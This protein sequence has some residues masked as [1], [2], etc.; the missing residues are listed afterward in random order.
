MASKPSRLIF[1]I[2]FS[3]VLSYFRRAV[4]GNCKYFKRKKNVIHKF[5]SWRLALNKPFRQE[6]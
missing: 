5:D 4:M 2:H 3:P 1:V 6:D